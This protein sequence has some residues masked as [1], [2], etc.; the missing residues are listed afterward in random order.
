MSEDERDL[1]ARR[2]A[3]QPVELVGGET[4]ASTWMETAAAAVTMGGYNTLCELLARRKK[5][6]VVPRAGP[7]AEQRIRTGLFSERRLIAALDPDGVGPD[8]LAREL[9]RLVGD[10]SIPNSDA[11]PRFDGA[12]RAARLLLAPEPALVGAAS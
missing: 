10:R 11:L 1:L 4:D 6:L 12:R 5:T 9:L 3:G 8:R 2:A 7:S